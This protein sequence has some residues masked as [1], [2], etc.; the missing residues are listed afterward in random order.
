[1]KLDFGEAG[2]ALD[3]IGENDAIGGG[4]LGDVDI[5]K[6]ASGVEVADIVI[7]GEPAVGIA[8]LDADVAANEIITDGDWADVLD[9][10]SDDFTGRGL[11]RGLRQHESPKQAKAA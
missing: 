9:V 5:I 2:F 8:D 11:G 3:G 4:F 6:E 1:M 7:D 10:D